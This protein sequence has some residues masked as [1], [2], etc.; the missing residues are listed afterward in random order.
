MY[1]LSKN[2][3]YSLNDLESMIPWERDLYVEQLRIDIEKEKI[4][5][6]L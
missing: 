5:N 3:G 6:K 2:Y 4:N 1:I